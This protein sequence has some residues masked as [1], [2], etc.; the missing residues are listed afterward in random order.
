M[1]STIAQD[2][3]TRPASNLPKPDEFRGRGPLQRPVRPDA[4]R[5]AIDRT[6]ASRTARDGGH[7]HE[8]A[9]EEADT[10]TGR[11]MIAPPAARGKGH[12]RLTPKISGPGRHRHDETT[13]ERP[14]PT[15]PP[16]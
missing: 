10:A 15:A 16:G 9:T 2:Q 3:R 6:T 12:S 4:G 1:G 8:T 14:G 7:A 11:P 5:T 13:D